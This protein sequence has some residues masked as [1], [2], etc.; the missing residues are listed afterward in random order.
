MLVQMLTP[1]AVADWLLVVAALPPA[2]AVSLRL[3]GPRLI[4]YLTASNPHQSSWYRDED[5]L[6]LMMIA[7]CWVFSVTVGSVVLLVDGVLIFKGFLSFG[8][9]QVLASV[10]LAA[11]D[12]LVPVVLLALFAAVTRGVMKML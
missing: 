3:F 10:I 5:K 2:L 4:D 7:A 9:G 6:E 12:A 1:T 8:Q 11:V